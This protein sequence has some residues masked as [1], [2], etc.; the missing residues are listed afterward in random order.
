MRVQKKLSETRPARVSTDKS[1]KN[2]LSGILFCGFCGAA[3]TRKSYG[4]QNARLKCAK[5]C[6][7]T[8]S[9]QLRETEN[10]LIDLLL[11]CLSL[12]ISEISPFSQ[13]LPIESEH[14]SPPAYSDETLLS[15]VRRKN[16]ENRIGKISLQL[17]R[18]HDLL[19][20]GI[21]DQ[22][23][24]LRRRSQLIEEGETLKKKMETLRK[25]SHPYTE[26]KE[27]RPALRSASFLSE[28]RIP[29]HQNR[30][31][32]DLLRT[33]LSESDAESKNALLRLIVARAEYYRSKADESGAFYLMVTLKI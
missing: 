11:A 13:K 7:D 24:F 4:G 18:Q 10:R 1:V 3:M 12:R 32:F 2:P 31:G 28:V 22:E 15:E 23:T 25:I 29:C 9:S 21:Y 19:E 26:R 27:E 5:S 8:K 16:L 33:V 17:R 30:G 20:Q 6:P 14:L